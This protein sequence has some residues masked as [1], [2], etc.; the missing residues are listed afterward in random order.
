MF[1]HEWWIATVAAM[2]LSGC[3]TLAPGVQ[4]AADAYDESLQAAELWMCR[5][6]SVGA[7]V[8][9]YGHSDEQWAAWRTL[10]GYT[11]VSIPIT[12]EVAK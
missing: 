2:A 7:V 1:A 12:G 10:C 4:R 9:A 3:T 11:G 5:G 6:A 8:R